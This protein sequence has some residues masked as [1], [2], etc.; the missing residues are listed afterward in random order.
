MLRYRFLRAVDAQMLAAALSISLFGLV[1]I[2][3]ASGML[4]GA[5][6][7]VAKQTAALVLGGAGLLGMA[8]LDY[9]A[10]ARASRHLYAA[11][12]L[13]LALVLILGRE[14]KGAQRWIVIGPFNLQ[15]SEIAKIILIVTLADHLCRAGEKIT[16]FAGLMQSAFHVAV[17]ALLIFKQPDLGTS[18]VVVVIWFGMTYLAGARWWHLLL[19]ALTLA[20]A[21]A[22]L[23][24]CGVLRPYQKQRLASFLNPDADP[25][26]S[27]YHIRQSRIAIGSGQLLGK[28]LHMGTQK[29]LRFV[30]ESHTDFIFTVVGEE[31]GFVGCIGL[32]GLY[33]LL[34]WRALRITMVCEDL[35]GQLI[36]GGVATLF[37]FH[38]L[39]NVGMTLGLAPVTGVPLLLF[40][41]GPSSVLSNLLAIGILQS[42]HMRR[43]KLMF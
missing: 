2:K 37:L 13:L 34:I 22:V 38:V 7:Y 18:L 17:P 11:N 40:S 23:W 3:S 19:C 8:M 21:F 20:A 29:K 41:Y 14:A 35:L 42:I 43:L 1:V 25:Q 27:G 30:P 31:L 16:A 36:A 39:V 24:S 26:G 4:A 10:V 12:I 5:S 32:L 33:L 15:P 28:G 9:R 6:A